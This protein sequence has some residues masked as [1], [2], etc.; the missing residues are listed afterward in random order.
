V[1]ILPV[2]NKLW[3]SPVT[4]SY[5]LTTARRQEIATLV[6]GITQDWCVEFEH[7]PSSAPTILIVP[8][9][10]DDDELPTLIISGSE[11]MFRLN[12]LHREDFRIWGEHRAW[13]DA[14]HA[15]QNWLLWVTTSH[16]TLH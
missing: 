12:E 9:D 10:S 1:W 6:A 2:V 13:P 3:H 5:R 16:S 11:S 8:Y 4:D 14:V 15:V 7:E